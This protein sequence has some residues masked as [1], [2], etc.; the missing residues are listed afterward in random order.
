MNHYTSYLKTTLACAALSLAPALLSALTVQS[1][2]DGSDGALIVS[3]DTILM[4]PEDGVFNYTSVLV[5][6]EATL[7]FGK[8]AANT[9]VYILSTGDITIE[10]GIDVSGQDTFG[11]EGGQGG[12]GGWDGGMQRTSSSK[13]GDG[14][15]PGGGRYYEILSDIGGSYAT[16]G[17]NHIYTAPDP[18]II[19]NELY[20]SP[21]LVPLLGGSGGS[22]SANSSSTSASGGGGGGGAILLASDTQITVNGFLNA[23][24]GRSLDRS[25]DTF[26]S[27]N[28]GSGGAIRLLAPIV[29]GTSGTLNA[30]GGFFGYGDGFIRI[31]SG[32]SDLENY[33]GV[34][35]YG[36]NTTI[37]PENQPELRLVTVAGNAIPDTSNAE[38]NVNLPPTGQAEQPVTVRASNFNSLVNV[39]IVLVPTIGT[40]TESEH[41]IDNRFEP[42]TEQT[43]NVTFPLDQLV[44]VY[45]FTSQTVR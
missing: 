40:R 42:V 34:V 25:T 45:V 15:G 28:S 18:D 6:S 41:T 22:G 35:T 26:P 16:Y 5:E 32:F 1:G 17:R 9:P 8:N 19:L 4:L 20:G 24:G 27:L 21:I 30:N 31:D 36:R 3:A 7:R 11:R 2:S 10:G 33:F 12:P 38:V 29:T 43:F 44:D 13:G 37:F 23:S 39:R 14:K